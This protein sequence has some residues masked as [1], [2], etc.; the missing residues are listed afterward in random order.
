[1]SRAGERD[2][3]RWHAYAT[4]DHDIAILSHIEL[5]HNGMLCTKFA[6]GGSNKIN[7]P[8]LKT[9][10][11]SQSVLAAIVL[12]RARPLIHRTDTTI[13]S[14]RR[15]IQCACRSGVRIARG[16]E[17]PECNPYRRN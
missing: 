14:P 16:S 17:S 13:N 9:I 12:L 7:A 2:H 3:F 15:R 4:L 10:T 8:R 5:Y 11:T 6:L 1:M